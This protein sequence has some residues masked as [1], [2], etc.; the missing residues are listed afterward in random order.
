MPWLT[1]AKHAAIF[2]NVIA[3]AVAGAVASQPEGP[4]VVGARCTAAA[5]CYRRIQTVTPRPTSSITNRPS[6]GV[7]HRP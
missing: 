4:R 6:A 7:T 5:V 3:V 2:G 1:G